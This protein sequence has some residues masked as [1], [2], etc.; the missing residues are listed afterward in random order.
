MFTASSDSRNVIDAAR[1][2]AVAT[3]GIACWN[4][5]RRPE[6]YSDMFGGIGIL[7]ATPPG[8]TEF[9]RMPF[10]PYRTRNRLQPDRPRY[11]R[12]CRG[13]NG[14][15]RLGAERVKRTAARD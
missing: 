14:D 3:V 10:G 7:V 11:P 13:S 1:C 2:S 12:D 8:A 6:P 15:A 4:G 5:A 9:T